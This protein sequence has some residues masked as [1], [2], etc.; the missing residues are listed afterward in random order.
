MR[1][2]LDRS[3]PVAYAAM[4]RWHHSRQGSSAAAVAF[5]VALPPDPP[6]HFVTT[7]PVT[8]RRRSRLAPCPAERKHHGPGVVEAVADVLP[9]FGP[10]GAGPPPW[11]SGPTVAGGG[12]GGS[13]GAGHP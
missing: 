10:E 7:W 2:L 6:A 4:P 8:G 12:A 11:V 3:H 1:S 9:R 13:A 5:R